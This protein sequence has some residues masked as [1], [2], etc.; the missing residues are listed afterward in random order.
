MK[1]KSDQIVIFDTT[2]RDGEQSPGASMTIEEKVQMA[3]QL[4]RL[5][6]NVIEAGFPVISDGDFKAVSEI[7]RQVKG[8]TIC[9]LARAVDNDIEAA[10]KALSEAE[11]K[12]IHV[13]IATSDIH[14]EH[15]LKMT[16]EQVVLRAVSAVKKAR[17]YVTDVE[18]SAEDAARTDLDFLVHIIEAVVDAGATTVNIPDTVGYATPSEFGQLIKALKTRVRNIEQ[19]V[20]SVHCHNDLGLATANSL[21]AVAN[22]ARQVECTVNGIGERSGN[23]ALEEIVMAL[24]TR[25]DK[26]AIETDINTRELVNSSKMVE[27]VTGIHVQPNKAIVGR[28]SFAH[29]AGIHQH[30]VIANRATYEIMRA[31]DVGFESN[32]IVLGKHSGRHAIRLWLDKNKITLNEDEITELSN[33]VKALSD[34]QKQISDSDVFAILNQS[35]GDNVVSVDATQ[36][37]G[38]KRW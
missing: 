30:G 31:E 3:H 20:I 24:K 19:A 25:H 27:E 4:K 18:F 2:L 34:T 1:N 38:S 11:N 21:A 13:F 9:A 17:S 8:P 6:V 37:L 26:F 33:K 14:M 5:G 28:N 36:Y 35:Q 22:G 32:E 15:K 12:R 10:A 23:C 16:R 29:E 7:A